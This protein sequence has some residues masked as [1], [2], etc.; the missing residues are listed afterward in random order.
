MKKFVI[1]GVAAVCRDGKGIHFV[2]IECFLY[3]M[4]ALP[5]RFARAG[6]DSTGLSHLLFGGV[7]AAEAAIGRRPADAVLAEAAR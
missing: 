2:E 7:P 1:P 3:R 5:S 6:H 4:D